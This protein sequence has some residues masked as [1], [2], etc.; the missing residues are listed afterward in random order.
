LGFDV[1]KADTAE[2]AVEIVNSYD[3]GAVITKE[4]L[5]KLKFKKPVTIL[6]PKTLVVGVGSRKDVSESEIVGAVNFALAR[7]SVPLERVNALATVSIKKD[8]PSMVNAA[9][10]LGLPLDFLDVES[11]RAFKHED[12]SPDS[13]MVK[14]KI[15]VGGVCERAALIE[16]GKKAKLILKK[17]KLDGV[18]VAIAEGE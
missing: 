7:V 1:K 18:T 2:Q 15:G 3:A 6:K 17:T 9:K 11:L 4:A 8:S 10:T 5:P 14:R 13:E 12:L 16:A